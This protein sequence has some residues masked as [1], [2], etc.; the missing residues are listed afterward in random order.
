MCL[1]ALTL[2]KNIRVVDLN[3]S[4]SNSVPPT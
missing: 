4:E 2:S 1:L 3:V